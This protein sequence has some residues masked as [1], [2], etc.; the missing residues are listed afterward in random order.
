[1]RIDL[2][3]LMAEEMA[4][5]DA[6]AA[7]SR[8]IDL[9]GM[10]GPR[11][12]GEGARIDLGNVQDINQSG[13]VNREAKRDRADVVEVP[14]MGKGIA[15]EALGQGALMG[16][17]DELEAFLTGRA[18]E[19]IGRE[20]AA[21]S[22]EHPAI[23]T[24]AYGGGLAATAGAPFLMRSA[25]QAMRGGE[26][27]DPL[28][29]RVEPDFRQAMRNVEAQ[30]AR[31]GGADSKFD[32]LQRL[33]S[34]PEARADIRGNPME[35][36]PADIF[37]MTGEENNSGTMG[38]DQ[39][40]I[41]GISNGADAKIS[42]EEEAMAAMSPTDAIKFAAE[43]QA[44]QPVTDAERAKNLKTTGMDALSVI[45]GPA[46]V[47][48]AKDAADSSG[49]AW[50]AFSGGDVKGGLG[51]TALAALGVLGA[52][53]GFP[54]SRTAGKVAEGA[55]GRLNTFVG[56]ESKTADKVAL[57]Q[58]EALKEAGADR[59]TIWKATGWGW[60]ERGL[61]F[62]EIDDSGA[63]LK[64]GMGFRPEY[65]DDF[66]DHPKLFEARPDIAAR[67]FSDSAP[68]GGGAH[69]TPDMMNPD[70][71]IEVGP[72]KPARMVDV[73]LHEGQHAAD[74]GRGASHGANSRFA[75]PEA[76]EEASQAMSS[77]FGDAFT[78]WQAAENAYRARFRDT[79]LPLT[80]ADMDAAARRLAI[81]DSNLA[82][83]QRS[84]RPVTPTNYAYQHNPGETRARNVE[85]RRKLSARERRETPPWETIDVDEA[86]I[87]SGRGAVDA[88]SQVLVPAMDSPK[89]ARALEMRREGHDMPFIWR[90]T[91]R[92]FSPSG[93][94]QR[95]IPD[96]GMTFREGLKPGDKL[97]LG[98]A[99][100][101]P[102]LFEAV[103]SLKERMLEV[104]SGRDEIGNRVMRTKPDGSFSINPEGGGDLRGPMAKLLQYEINRATKGSAP[105]RH[106]MSALERGVD[107]AV[108][109]VD[110]LDPQN[111]ATRAAI[112]RY[113]DSLAEVKDEYSMLR[114]MHGLTGG[115]SVP[116]A[117]K[118]LQERNAGNVE[119]RVAQRR[120]EF[121]PDDM[122]AWPYRRWPPEGM[123]GQALPK[124]G[125]MFVLP[126]EG[127][128]GR[129]L[130]AFIE[131][132]D[133]LGAGR[134]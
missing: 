11:T 100:S 37:M 22:D 19:D 101:H 54:G 109:R 67:R 108:A 123:K 49:A 122:A 79:S 64:D 132:W 8:R 45:P 133:E 134:K 129:D 35:L 89:T 41:P 10:P 84:P 50:N 52:V 18:S 48:S 53:T 78:E 58:A 96:Q 116:P 112:D 77:K 32:Q 75:P 83:A 39:Q 74:F 55:S 42:P 121:K 95:E 29:P 66:L 119:A 4:A 113:L 128:K 33:L 126:P 44:A 98:E 97:P 57:Q 56:P 130:R 131:A 127:L 71:R 106:G 115:A 99:M 63:K 3:K 65:F 87:L 28:P 27:A 34:S 9:S 124:F 72:A 24:A 104:T 94:V 20:R 88:P 125:S 1:M 7:A 81:A 69:Y 73:A 38:A 2:A 23:A 107:D 26:K 80:G 59:D 16:L 36:S 70:G 76:L 47:L 12:R 25:M 51:N 68:P 31:M 46:Q 61:P 114:E 13:K 17:G 117:A 118:R 85:A 40:S 111:P 102:K 120:A 21:F 14:G 91:D 30:E 5:A 92:A 90:E 93:Q 105:L 86:D 43:A 6:A 15:R 60:D 110:R 62:Y 103:P 82:K